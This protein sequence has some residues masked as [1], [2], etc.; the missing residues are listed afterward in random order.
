MREVAQGLFWL[1]SYPGL[2][3]TEYTEFQFPKERS[4][5]LKAEYSWTSELLRLPT[6]S[7][8]TSV[9]GRVGIPAKNFP[10]KA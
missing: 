8:A 5:I 6:G 1:D 3:R 4:Y 2:G 7:H 9:G 10:K